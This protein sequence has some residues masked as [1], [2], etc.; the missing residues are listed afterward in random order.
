MK[1][2]ITKLNTL[3][4]IKFKGMYYTEGQTRGSDSLF[5]S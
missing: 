1:K 5:W 3:V 2:K 4:M